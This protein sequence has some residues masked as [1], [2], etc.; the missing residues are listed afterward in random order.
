MFEILEI[1]PGAAVAD[2]NASYRRLAKK[3]HPDFNRGRETWAHAMMTDLNLAYEAALEHFSSPI[4]GVRASGKPGPRRGAYRVEFKEAID[5]VLKAL[6]TYYQYGLENIHLRGEGVRRLRFRECVN[7]LKSGIDL[8][9]AVKAAAEE[10]EEGENLDVFTDFAK[11]FFQN[12]LL[13]RF[14]TP[15]SD[16]LETNAYR[17]FRDGSESLDYAVKDVFFGDL[18][19]PVR[20]G[21]FYRKI[22]EGYE[23]FLLV[24]SNYAESSWTAEAMIKLYLLQTLTR[25]I[26]F[27]E[28]MR[29]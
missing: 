26:G 27:L 6:Y 25:V 2:L 4:R 21:S 19:I 9:E 11:A 15:T 10:A 22:A 5:R 3:Y 1:G 12:A 28:T 7:G 8:L 13:D 23:S 20:K 18:L 24:L 17:H 14:H 16:R 29:H